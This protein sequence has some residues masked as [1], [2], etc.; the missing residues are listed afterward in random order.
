[1]TVPLHLCSCRLAMEAVAVVTEDRTAAPLTYVCGHCDRGG[2]DTK[3]CSLC[4]NL[5][6]ADAH[7]TKS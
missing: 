4:R 3:H 5:T 6:Q 1:M 2:C 7:N